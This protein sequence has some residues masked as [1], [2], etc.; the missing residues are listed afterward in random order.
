MASVGVPPAF[1]MRESSAH[2]V[3]VDCLPEEMNG[4]KIRD[5]KDMEAAIIDGKYWWSKWST[6]TEIALEMHIKV[7]EVEGC[8]CCIDHSHGSS[9]EFEGFFGC[10]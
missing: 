4:M 9:A 7:I 2:T 3:G 1:G 8:G 6:K 10:N 5:D